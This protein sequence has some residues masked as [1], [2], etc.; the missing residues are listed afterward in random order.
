MADDGSNFLAGFGFIISDAAQNVAEG[1]TAAAGAGVGFTMSRDEMES[2]LTKANGTAALIAQQLTDAADIARID[3]PGDDGSSRDFT[4]IAVDS[5]NA[6][7]DHL[8]TQQ[9]RYGSLIDKL[10]QALGHTTEAD[11]QAAA[12]VQAADPKGS[13]T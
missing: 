8:R 1:V 13:I 7:L 6:Y 11:H 10:N 4:K 2:M 12:A 9:A 5:G 3:P